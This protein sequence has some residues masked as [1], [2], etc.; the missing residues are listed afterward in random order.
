MI[1]LINRQKGNFDNFL[2]NYVFQSTPL[3]ENSKKV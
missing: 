3:S 2:R 1:K